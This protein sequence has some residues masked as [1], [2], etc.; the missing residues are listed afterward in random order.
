MCKIRLILFMNLLCLIIDIDPCQYPHIFSKSLPVSLNTA[1]K[2]LRLSVLIIFR[3]LPIKK[4]QI[5]VREVK[6][7]DSKL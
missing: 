4:G 5:L 2:A 1:Q 6:R 3:R 7:Q